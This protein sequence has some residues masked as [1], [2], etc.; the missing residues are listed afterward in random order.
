MPF[1][2]LKTIFRGIWIFFSFQKHSLGIL[3][4]VDMIALHISFPQDLQVHFYAM[5]TT[6]LRSGPLEGNKKNKKKLHCRA[7]F[8]DVAHYHIPLYKSNNGHLKKK[9]KQIIKHCAF[10][11]IL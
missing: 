7:F 2:V 3:V 4:H 6:P 8:S 11:T 1:I 9:K 10:P 5:F